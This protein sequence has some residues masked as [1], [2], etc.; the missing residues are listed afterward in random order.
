MAEKQQGSPRLLRKE[1]ERSGDSL[2]A[3]GRAGSAVAEQQ[4]QRG[5]TASTRGSRKRDAG[6]RAQGTKGKREPTGAGKWQLCELPTSQHR[7]QSCSSL[8]QL[9]PHTAWQGSPRQCHRCPHA[10]GAGAAPD[11]HTLGSLSG[12]LPT[13]SWPLPACLRQGGCSATANHASKEKD[14]EQVPVMP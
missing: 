7:A 1:T 4:S 13:P 6:W 9:T 12:R 3:R 5:G 14:G 2:G 11:S 10:P 8:E